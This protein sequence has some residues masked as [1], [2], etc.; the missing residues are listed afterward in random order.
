[1][2]VTR[3][4]DCAGPLLVLAGTLFATQPAAADE[5]GVSFW[6]PGQFGSFAA[7]PASP[8]WSLGAVY[9]HASGDAGGERQ[10]QRGGRIAAGLDVN[11]DLLFLAPSYAFPEPVLG[12]QLAL[13]LTG[14]YG[15]AKVDTS[16]T[17][18]GPLGR[19]LTTGESDSR[20]GIGDLYPMASLKWHQG[21]HNFMAYGMTGVPVGAYD[22]ERLANIGTNHWSLDA[23]GGYTYLDDKK[24]HELSAVLGFTYNFENS[25]T[26]YRN[27]TDMHFD[28]AASQFFSSTFHAG[29]AGYF[30]NQVSGD[31]GTGAQL[32]DFKS[33]VSAIGPQ[34]GWF[35]KVGDST[36]YANLKGFYEFDAKNRPEGWSVWATLSLPL[37]PSKK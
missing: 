24:G 10:F 30:Y 37:G 23:G 5:G 28:W 1:M 19:S 4:R 26:D 29:L 14:L 16:A 33:R 27:G 25:D 17:L 32:G 36:W 12:G 22:K 31:S 11:A 8:G 35:F 9:Y 15:R 7:V 21:L 13:Q 2:L 6:L 18:S 34:M 20:T 3:R